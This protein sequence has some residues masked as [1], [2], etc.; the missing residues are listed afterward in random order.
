M[1]VDADAASQLGFPCAKA[2]QSCADEVR[3]ERRDEPLVCFA[4]DNGKPMVWPTCPVRATYDDPHIAA[5]LHLRR[6]RA[7]GL[8]LV[9]DDYAAWVTDLWVDLESLEQE[10]RERDRAEK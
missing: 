9:P 8:Q 2:R 4:D 7:L 1:I 5:V 3:C 6:M 10:K